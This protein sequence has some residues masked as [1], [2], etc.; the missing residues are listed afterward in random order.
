MS[1]REWIGWIVATLAVATAVHIASMWYLPRA[2]MHVAI[3]R[4]GAV[5]AIHHGKRVDATSRGVVRPSPDLLY[6]TC[7]FDLSKGV[8][9]VKAPVPPDTYWSA[10]AFDANTNNF[11]AIN[12]RNIGGQPLELIVLPPGHTQEPDHIAGQL[13]IHSP[14]VRGLI[15]FRTL[16]SDEKQ[17]ARVDAVR[18]QANCGVLQ[19][20]SSGG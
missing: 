10:S 18:R 14:S 11:F 13:V 7:P 5:N 4:M 17:F 16:I 12:D 2:V 9:E 20:S 15:L 1:A 3:S 8:L 6:S 19:P